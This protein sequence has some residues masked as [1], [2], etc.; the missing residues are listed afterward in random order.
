MRHLIR[1]GVSFRIQRRGKTRRAALVATCLLLIAGVIVG[2]PGANSA[3]ATSSKPAGHDHD[4]NNDGKS[5]DGHDDVNGNG[6]H[7]DNC[8]KK[9]HHLNHGRHRGHHYGHKPCATTARLTLNKIVINDNDGTST[10][11]DFTLTATSSVGGVDVINGPDLEADSDVGITADVAAPASYVLSESGPGGYD[12]SNWECSSGDL[13]GDT[14][15]LAAGDVAGCTITNDD[16]PPESGDTGTITLL[17]AVTNAWGG[18]LQPA[19]FQLTIDNGNVPQG[20]AQTVP[21]GPHV[22][23]E[24][25]SPGYVQTDIVCT[26][27]ATDADVAD[28]DGSIQVGVGQ[29]V[30]CTVF[31]AD[32]APTLTVVKHVNP[33]VVPTAAPE[34]FQLTIDDQDVFQN[35]PQNEVVGTHTVGEVAVDGYRLA[36]I[37]CTLDGTNTVVAYTDG[38]TLALDQHVT[39]VVTNQHDPI[40]LAITK[41][42]IDAPQVAG[43]APFDYTIT[44]D[45]LGPRDATVDDPATVTDHLPAGFSFLTF[46]DNCTS[47]LQTLTCTVAATDLEV[48]DLPV[49]L[50]VTVNVGPDIASGTYTNIAYVD[51]P[52]DPACLGDDCVPACDAETNNVACATVDVVRQSSLSVSKV[53]DVDSPVHPGDSYAYDITVTNAGPSSLLPNL[54]LTDALPADVVLETIDAASPW[55]CTGDSTIVCTYGAAL[56]RGESAAVIRLHVHILETSIL[57]S[58]TNVAQATALVEVGN[59]VTGTGSEVTPIAPNAELSIDTSASTTPG[60]SGLLTLVVARR[61]RSAIA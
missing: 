53:D 26:D 34:S 55:T 56:A 35:A 31:N 52:G 6:H 57:D 36:A 43:G 4:K 59:V 42:V 13:V 20:V 54:T 58:V 27:T 61:R 50:T 5:N 40:D 24:L 22:I 23:A 10:V 18:T 30:A 33:D 9:N 47:A 41:T 32:V 8:E 46:P 11:A 15:T 17:K 28:V 29:D 2:A 37:N 14:L 39:C 7:E 38:V 12:A 16:T 1:D 19:D 21:G 44:V 3:S 25:P 49:V 51:T 45:N 48:A 60:A